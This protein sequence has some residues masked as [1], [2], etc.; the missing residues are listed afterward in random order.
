MLTLIYLS[1]FTLT[2]FEQVTVILLSLG[3]TLVCKLYKVK[4]VIIKSCNKIPLGETGCNFLGYFS[5]PAT[6]HHDYFQLS[7]FLNY[8]GVQFFD[9]PL[10]QY[11]Q[12][13][14][15]WLLTPHCAAP[16]WLKRGY[17][18]SLVTRYFPPNPYLGKQKTSVGVTSTLSICLWAHT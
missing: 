9:S 4:T 10:S 1:L 2:D 16:V 14:Y 17:V 12:L 15:F 3:K 8:P 13:G 6:L 7:T 11:S 5:L 18:T